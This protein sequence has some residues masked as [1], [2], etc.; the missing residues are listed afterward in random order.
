[1]EPVIRLGICLAMF[2]MLTAALAGCGGP[3]DKI[4]APDQSGGNRADGIVSMSS[5]V[6]VFHPFRPDWSEAMI[7]ADRRCRAWG[8]RAP[9]N[10]AGEREQCL[11]WDR[12]GRCTEMRLTRYYQCSSG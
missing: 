8:Y 1:M 3:G 9:S 12:H 4:V 5:K 2:V 6:T 11:A 7:G 10:L